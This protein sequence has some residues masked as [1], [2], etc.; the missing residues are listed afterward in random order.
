MTSRRIFK[1]LAGLGGLCVLL[2]LAAALLLPRIL[3]SQAVKEK[4]RAFL[5]TRMNGNVAIENIDLK[6]LPRPAVV[7]RGASL[8]F[9]DKVSGK[10][11]S[12]AVY[13]SMLGL[14]RGDLEISRVEAASPALSVHLPEPAEEPF[15]IDEIEGQIRSLLTALAAEIPGMIVT[16]SGGSAE[17]RIGDRPPVVITDLDGRFRAPPGDMD[18]QIS[19][20]ANVFDSLRVEGRVSGDTSSRTDV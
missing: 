16:V 4:I 17:V 19:S 5:L 6:W 9:A 7:V 3:D 1:W 2:F 8:A 11:Q 18:L 12:L 14:L 15:N 20:R 10:I 13:P